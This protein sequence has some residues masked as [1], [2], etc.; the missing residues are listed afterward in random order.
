VAR[1]LVIVACAV[2]AGIHGALAPAHFTESAGAGIGFAV[3]AALL[4][5]LAVAFAWRPT[6]RALSGAAAVLAGLLAS[7]VLAVTTGLPLLHPEPEPVE[8][9]A[10]VTKAVEAIGLVAAV[11]LLLAPTPRPRGALT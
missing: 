6:V 7:Y 3:A 8:A 11:H 5:T 2:S 4:A 10:L 9:L 1:N